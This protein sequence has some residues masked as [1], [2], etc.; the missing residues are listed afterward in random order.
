M[1]KLI[2]GLFIIAACCLNL[3]VQAESMD[4][5]SSSKSGSYT[6]DMSDRQTANNNLE[7]PDYVHCNSCSKGGNISIHQRDEEWCEHHACHHHHHHHG[8]HHHYHHHHN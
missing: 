5:S 1:K 3:N 7:A 6:V 4:A 2:L 8:H